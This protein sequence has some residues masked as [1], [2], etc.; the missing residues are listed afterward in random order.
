[1][2]IARGTIVTPLAREL[3]K[4]RGVAIVELAPEDWKAKA[5]P[6]RT[7]V[8]GC[9][10]G[11]FRMKQVLKPVLVGL[12]YVVEDIGTFDD[13][14][15]DYPDIAEQVAVHV[16]EGRAFAGVMID[17]AGIGS[18]MAANKVPGIRAAL[19]YDRASA[20]NSREH[21][22]A[23]VL[24]LGGRMLTDSQAEE[25]LRTWFST[26]WGEGRHQARIDKIAAIEARY[27]KGNPA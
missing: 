22:H 12:G 6:H 15:A 16:K 24:T 20:R 27:R 21:N 5:E 23:N 14:P 9:D 2:E 1:L 7:V 25:V 8:I 19:C 26:P 11:G 13:R 10:H 3:A 18:A 4:E 17:G